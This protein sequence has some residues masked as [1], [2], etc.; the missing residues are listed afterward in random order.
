MQTQA[1]TNT[2]STSDP[3]PEVQAPTQ[4]HHQKRTNQTQQRKQAGF[5]LIEIM[6]VSIVVGVIALLS[7]P[8]ITSYLVSARVSPTA[9]DIAQAVLRIRANGEGA[10]PTPYTALATSTV[11]NTLRDRTTAITISAAVGA[12][13]TA[14]HALGETG[15]TITAAPATITTAGD[16][17]T[18]TFSQV[19]KGA[20]PSLSTQLQNLAEIITIN[21]A[22]VKSI[23]AGT[24]Y[25]G[26]T[27]E[28]QCT[29]GN[30]NT[31]VFTFR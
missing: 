11:A 23:P 3:Q 24:A 17:F 28:T 12:S 13:A 2:P 4:S 10:G 1:H 8:R 29:A 16:S 5:T 26:Q 6:I 25:N 20:C 15:A 27:A 9:N 14:S 31:F 30:T 18:V 22:V 19:N 7:I 21:T